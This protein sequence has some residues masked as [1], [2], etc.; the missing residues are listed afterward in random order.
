MAMLYA[1]IP[2]RLQGRVPSLVCSGA[3]AR[4]P[5]GLAIA[6]P[7]VDAVGLR[8]LYWASGVATVGVAL[9]LLLVPAARRVEEDGFALAR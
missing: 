5:L 1:T 8:P 2:S 7:V 9:V 6:G 3:Q 4:M